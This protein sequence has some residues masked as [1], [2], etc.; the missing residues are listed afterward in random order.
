MNLSARRYAEDEGWPQTLDCVRSD[1]PGDFC[2]EQL[3][4]AAEDCADDLSTVAEL[5]Q[6]LMGIRADRMNLRM[7]M[8][9]TIVFA[10]TS[11]S[12][13]LISLIPLFPF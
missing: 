1:S 12:S 3:M 10:C 2:T 7:R 5:M 8:Q 4:Q 6:N 13:Q 9:V 11:A